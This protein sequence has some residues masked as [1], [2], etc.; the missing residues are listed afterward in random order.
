MSIMKTQYYFFIILTMLL[1]TCK[2]ECKETTNPPRTVDGS[3]EKFFFTYKGNEAIKF[4]KNTTDTVILYGQGI[5]TEY[6]YTSTQDD[7]PT[8][9]PLE[10]KYVIFINSTSSIGFLIQLY[11]TST[12]STYCILKVNDKTVYN[13]HTAS[14][15]ASPVTLNVLNT[16]YDNVYYIGDASI[17]LYYQFTYKGIVKF[18]YYNDIYEL[19]PN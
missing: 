1:S 10:N 15:P 2:Q 12:F 13:G 7:C 4:L 9:I 16:N 18:K 3:D 19:I 6:Q 8:K 14:I 17:G 11:M 5:K